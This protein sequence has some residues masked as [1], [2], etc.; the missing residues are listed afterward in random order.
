[1]SLAVHKYELQPGLSEVAIPA[2]AK[3]LHVG[4]IDGRV[5]V[6]ALVDPADGLSPRR[7]GFMDTGLP[8]PADCEYVG[9]AV[10]RRTNLVR[11]VF[12]EVL[13]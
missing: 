5:Y 9:T 4:V 10:D 11:H 6:W 2:T 7:I 12:E 13:F 8:I 1:V 3:L